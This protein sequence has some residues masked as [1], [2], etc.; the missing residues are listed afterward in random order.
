MSASG[1][2]SPYYIVVS[3]LPRM[4]LHHVCTD[5]RT[6]HVTAKSSARLAIRHSQQ[7]DGWTRCFPCFRLFVQ[8]AD[9]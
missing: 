9:G 2:Q 3:T 7:A 4:P 6:V 8:T 5:T 1:D